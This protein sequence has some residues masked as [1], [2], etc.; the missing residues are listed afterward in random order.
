[1]RQGLHAHSGWYFRRDLGGHVVIEVAESDREDAPLRMAAVFDPD[2]WASAVASV[3]AAGET[4]GT[5]DAAR[6][7]HMGERQP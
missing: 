4:S 2:T 3:S 6:A 5:Y 7:L 1:M